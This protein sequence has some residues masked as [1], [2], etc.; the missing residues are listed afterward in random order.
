[1]TKLPRGCLDMDRAEYADLDNDTQCAV[2]AELREIARYTMGKDAA[3]S[4]IRYRVMGSTNTL[5]TWILAVKRVTYRCERCRG[6]GTYSGVCGSC[7]G[8]GHMNFDD[9]R[10]S[11]AYYE[12]DEDVS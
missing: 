12:G 7:G 1:M 3:E 11:R 8:K 10:R 2:Y 9:M 4:A 5:V 6:T